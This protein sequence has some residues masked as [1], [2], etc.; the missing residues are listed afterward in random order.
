MDATATTR[1]PPAAGQAAK[2]KLTKDSYFGEW[3][4][5][6]LKAANAYRGAWRMAKGGGCEKFRLIA[7]RRLMR[8]QALQLICEARKGR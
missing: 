4:W 7:I 3:S 8:E 5:A 2:N 6:Y 1:I